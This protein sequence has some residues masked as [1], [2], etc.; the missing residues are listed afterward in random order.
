VNIFYI[1]HLN[2]FIFSDALKASNYM[3]PL[4][5]IISKVK[6]RQE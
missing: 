2:N 6:Y 4:S 1:V 3:P 5:L